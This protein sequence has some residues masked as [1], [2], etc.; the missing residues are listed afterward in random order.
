[1]GMFDTVRAPCPACGKL[2]DF[3]TKMGSC[4]LE[5]FGVADAPDDLMQD[6]SRQPP[7]ACPCGVSFSI[8]I[9]EG[10]FVPVV[11]MQDKPAE[12][13]L[14]AARMRQAVRA[15]MLGVAAQYGMDETIRPFA[16]AIST[17]VYWKVFGVGDVTFA[18]ALESM[19]RQ[20][21]DGVVGKKVDQIIR[22]I[23]GK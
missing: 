1:M 10:R 4:R 13:D 22:E 20:A 15:G 7:M 14:Y 9:L 21:A 11:G 17:L 23:E 3:Q 19:E 2:A 18:K 8:G 6:V 16:E 5:V 12:R